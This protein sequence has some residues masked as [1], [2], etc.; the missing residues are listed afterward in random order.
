MRPDVGLMAK[1]ATRQRA[2]CGDN[3]DAG[4]SDVPVSARERPTQGRVQR[5]GPVPG[6]RDGDEHEVVLEAALRVPQPLRGVHGRDRNDH[7]DDGSCRQ[8][9]HKPDRE[10]QATAELGHTA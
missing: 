10:Q 8:R 1:P 6:E 2:H 4:R 7:A 3:C 5:V 9:R